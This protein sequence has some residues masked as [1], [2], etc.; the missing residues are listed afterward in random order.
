MK[1]T[2]L[3]RAF[4]KTSG[5]SQTT[6]TRATQNALRLFDLGVEKVVVLVATDKDCG[7]TAGFIRSQRPSA[8]D[9]G[10]R[11]I[12]ASGDNSS[13]VLN[14]GVGVADLQGSDVA[15][16]ISGKAV[17]SLTRRDLLAMR[18]GFET[19]QAVGAIGLT[20]DTDL[21]PI[22]EQGFL[23]NTACAWRIPL[24]KA[25]GGFT[26]QIGVEETTVLAIFA[27]TGRRSLVLRRQAKEMALRV[28]DDT[29][30]RN[31][32][33][34]WQRIDQELKRVGA[35]RQLVQDMVKGRIDI[36]V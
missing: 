20:L 23:Q 34:K 3:L 18:A 13:E 24:V 35:N 28:E 19:D 2:A 4:S 11:V 1:I 22:I 17:G 26:S 12:D 15:F 36:E 29:Y 10:F 6:A 7:T 8:C 27:A 5:D 31:L 21:G 9:I 25:A 14:T 32:E 33:T 30:W 16:I